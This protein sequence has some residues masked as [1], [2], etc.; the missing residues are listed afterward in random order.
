[1]SEIALVGSAIRGSASEHSGHTEPPCS[2]VVI[3]GVISSG[4]SRITVVGVQA[5]IVG[6]TTS[7]TCSCCGGGTGHVSSGS[8]RITVGG[9]PVA[10]NGSAVSPHSGTASVISGNGRI[11]GL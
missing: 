8:S 4:T 6:S 3:G 11:Y 5:G 9:I 7:E 10:K 1:M 2:G